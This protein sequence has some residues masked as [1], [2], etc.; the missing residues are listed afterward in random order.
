MKKIQFENKNGKSGGITLIAL[1]ITIIVL[2]ILAGISISMLSGDNSILQQSTNAKTKTMHATVFEHMQLEANAYTIDKTTGTYSKT[3]ID[4]LKDEKSIISEID[5]EE[6]K[7][8]IDVTKLLGSNQQMGVGTYPNDVYVLEKQDTS[9]GNILNTKV[10]TTTQIKIASTITNHVTYKIVYYESAEK[11]N[12]ILLGNLMDNEKEEINIKALDSDSGKEEFIMECTPVLFQALYRI[13][14]ELRPNAGDSFTVDWGDGETSSYSDTDTFADHIYYKDSSP[15][16]YE[17]KISGTLNSIEFNTRDPYYSKCL[18]KIKQWGT[19]NSKYL[20]LNGCTNLTEVAEP[21]INS[22]SNLERIR[23]L[24]CTSLTTVPENLF[25]NCPKLTDFSQTFQNCTSLTNVSKYLFYN[26]DNVVSFYRTFYN[27]TSLTGN[28]IP[29]WNR[30][31]NGEVNGYIGTPEGKNC[32]MGCTGLSN[33]NE[34]PNYWKN[35]P[36]TISY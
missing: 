19:L 18:R 24:N 13:R 28:A 10:A 12:N 34:I 17:I 11:G 20:S 22:F 14:F 30:V 6:N 16:T 36:D 21:T 15:S 27:C 29:L 31:E 4:Y 23:F 9:T 8:L 7:W 26:C 25:L 2:L 33:Y 3:L 1:V 32:F 5:G 35:I